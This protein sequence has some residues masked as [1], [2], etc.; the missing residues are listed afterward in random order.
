MCSISLAIREMQ[1]ETITYHF[2]PFKL[3]KITKIDTNS[4]W[5]NCGKMGTHTTLGSVNWYS[6]SG[7]QFEPIYQYSNAYPL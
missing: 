2:L 7:R 3:D 6:L 5:H 1:M 4:C